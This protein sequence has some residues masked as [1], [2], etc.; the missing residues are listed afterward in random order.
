MAFDCPKTSLQ[1]G[2]SGAKVKELQEALKKLGF[3]SGTVDSSFGPVTKNAVIA[4]QKRYGLKQDGWFGE[5][6][7]KKLATVLPE[8]TSGGG[9][10]V[11]DC[12]KT[13]LKKGSK[14]K[15]KVTTLQTYLKQWGYYEK[16]VDGD[17]GTYTELAVKDFQK[18]VGET[19]DGWFGQ[20]TCAKFVLKV[21]NQLEEE[22]EPPYVL[23]S[24]L[25]GIPPHARYIT[26]R[27]TMYPEVIYV[28]EQE[29]TVTTNDSSSSGSS[30][31]DT[32][33][34][35]TGGTGSGSYNDLDSSSSSS[36]DSSSTSSTESTPTTTTTTIKRYKIKQMGS[37]KAGS[38]A[39]GGLNCQGI[40]L[41]NGSS[42]DDVKTLQTGLSKMGYYTSTI[43]GQYGPKTVE[44]VKK[45]QAAT[46]LTQDGWFGEKT[47]PEYNKKLGVNTEKVQNKSNYIINDIINP[48]PNS[49]NE[50]LTHDCTLRTVYTREKLAGIQLM[51]RCLLEM[52]QD[53][54]VVYKLDGYVQDLKIVQENNLFMIELQVTGFSAFLEQDFAD[55]SGNKK[56]TEHLKDICKEI[57]LMLKLELNGLKDESIE[58]NKVTV[59]GGSS[60]SGGGKTVQMSN[61]DCDASDGVQS[62]HW[63]NHRTNPPQ[64]T[65]KSKEMH[66]NSDRQYA[67][68][69]ASHNGSSKEL[70]E[71]VQSKCQYQLYAD[72]PY[73]SS[74]C[75]DNMWKSGSSGKIRGNCADYARMLKC[76]LDVNGYQSIICHIPGH[77]YNAIWENGGWTVCDLCRVLYGDSAYGHANHGNVKPRG[78][79]D[80]PVG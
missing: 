44:A 26:S 9:A 52:I 12:P 30:S 63:A 67:R 4:F 35:D 14:E 58:L 73:G 36:D 39:G 46:G 37:G 50:G 59:S 60:S 18:E 22:T 68:D 48:Q 6:S 38:S 33:S 55:Y 72:N 47:C 21:K 75:P 41:Q 64:C 61:N 27:L 80:S 71:Y 56:Q 16:S 19:E 57:G 17:Y 65:A 34:T 54:D 10:D 62:H 74:R 32:S 78:T 8:T 20:K 11:F 69:T 24:H 43:D 79:W 76:I 66:G 45:L 29:I 5:L 51:Q 53:E 7:C 31:T 77:F 40:S 25:P 13:S 42:G 28:E 1:K 70:V 23:G 15:S 49:D 2:S 3:Y